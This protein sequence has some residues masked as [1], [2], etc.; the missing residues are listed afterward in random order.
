[1][2]RNIKDLYILIIQ[3]VL[4]LMTKIN[5]SINWQP[6]ISKIGS[7][8]LSLGSFFLANGATSFPQLATQTKLNEK[9]MN[10]EWEKGWKWTND[11]IH[12]GKYMDEIRFLF[13]D[14]SR[15]ESICCFNFLFLARKHSI[16]IWNQFFCNMATPKYP[17][18]CYIFKDCKC[19]QH[20][21]SICI[22]IQVIMILIEYLPLYQMASAFSFMRRQKD[23]YFLVKLC[24]FFVYTGPKIIIIN[25][26]NVNV[27]KLKI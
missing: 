12:S 26:D 20:N 1:M 3:S 25:V 18:I 9:Q 2:I 24:T 7:I 11:N 8:W 15:M 16:V 4:V 17:C 23:V 5:Q 14:E 22:Y 10:E 13:G 19:L 27:D 21:R 6:R